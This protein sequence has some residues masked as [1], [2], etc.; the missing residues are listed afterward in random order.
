MSFAETD[1]LLPAYQ[2]ILLCAAIPTLIAAAYGVRKWVARYQQLPGIWQQPIKQGL[3][4]AVKRF[5]REEWPRL[6]ALAI[7][8]LILAGLTITIRMI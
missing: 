1:L 4:S 6:I 3:H 7:L 5:T 8:L 2:L